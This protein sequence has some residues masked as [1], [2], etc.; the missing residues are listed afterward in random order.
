MICE[1]SAQLSH[2]GS[3]FSRPSALPS[4]G[5][6]SQCTVSTPTS[7]SQIFSLIANLPLAVIEWDPH[8]HIT[9]W[10]GNAERMFGWTPEEVIGKRLDEF[11]FVYEGDWPAVQGAMDAMEHGWSWVSHNRNYRRDGTLIHC[12]WYN[13][14]LLDKAGALRSGLSLVLDVTTRQGMET[15]LR[16]SEE[17]FRNIF[18]GAPIGIF[19]STVDGRFTSVNSRLTEMF[20]FASPEHMIRAVTDIGW[21]LFTDPEKR[22]AIVAHALEGTDFVQCEV[23]Y[24][25]VDGSVFLANLHMKAERQ[26]DG[27]VVLEGFVEDI[28]ERKRA[29][30]ALREAH[31]T[32]ERRVQERTAAAQPA[33]KRELGFMRGVPIA[34]S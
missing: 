34:A 29:D 27:R 15:A 13:S 25:R 6:G 19:Q 24:R 10:R 3:L 4:S 2:D 32:L 28:T 21:Q 20:G 9:G 26:A 11:R 14:V 33:G 12:E 31:D 5:A 18:E 23:E 30:E 8:H 17:K 7:T 1:A 22:R 16:A